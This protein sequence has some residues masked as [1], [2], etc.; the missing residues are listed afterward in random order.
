M[1][2]QVAA[3]C[4]AILVRLEGLLQYRLLQMAIVSDL[5]QPR[6]LTSDHPPVNSFPCFVNVVYIHK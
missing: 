6:P 4:I 5:H 1:R 2:R 3:A